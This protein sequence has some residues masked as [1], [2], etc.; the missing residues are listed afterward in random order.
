MGDI[1]A[2]ERLKKEIGLFSATAIGVGAVI[3]AGIFVITGI[4][5]GFAGPAVIISLI[6]AGVIAYFTAVSFSKLSESIT[7]EGGTYAF[8]YELVSPTAGFLAG[9][10]WI[11]S[12]T[13]V[14]ATVALGF[15]NYLIQYLP[16]LHVKII[17]V[18]VCFAFT[19]LNYFGVKEST[20]VNNVFVSTKIIVLLFFIVLG[21]GYI[22]LNFFTPFFISTEEWGIL[23]GTAL[24]F[25]AYTGFARITTVAEEVKNPTRIIPKSI[26]LT[27]I[28]SITLYVLTSYVAIGLVG[29]LTLANSDS[30]LSS[31][32]A[33]T[34]N[35]ITVLLI[36]I[37]AM[38]ATASVLLTAILGVSRVAFAMARNNDLPIYLKKIHTKYGTPYIAVWLA[39]WLMIA[40]VILTPNLSQVAA[41][42]S[43]ASLLYYAMANV[44]AIN[45][46]MKTGKFSPITPF[47]GLFSCLGLL[48]FLSFYAW[49]IGIA[50]LVLGF[51]YY[52]IRKSNKKGSKAK[53]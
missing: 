4:V 17:A 46:S 38:I 2:S 20:I 35:P 24:I 23:Q 52:F 10:M 51:F 13:F 30:P 33:V 26:L 47:I 22:N 28:I 29:H 50:G 45:L 25:F 32:I 49:I 27:L 8:V 5:A 14:G 40:A 21:L 34:G 42:S 16:W 43:F 7:R 36:S 44:A 18:A 39:G 37:G 15:A 1:D 19:L 12:Y 41:L 31:A 48:I 9:W 3:G 53:A 6:I 11:L